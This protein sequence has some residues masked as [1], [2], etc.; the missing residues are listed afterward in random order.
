MKN[1]RIT[2][3]DIAKEAGVGIATVSRVLNGNSNVKENTRNKVIEIIKKYNFKPNTAARNLVNQSFQETVIGVIVPRIDTQFIFEV[4]AGLYRNL[5]GRDYNILIF[6]AGKDRKAVFSHLV[7]EHLAGLI[8]FGDPPMSKDEQ[9]LIRQSNIPYIF[10][11]HHEEGEHFVSYNNTIG[12]E[13]AAEYLYEKGCRKISF[14]GLTDK[15]QQQRERLYSFKKKLNQLNIDQIREIYVPDELSSYN[16]TMSILQKD[17][18]DG[19]FYFSDQLAF[20]GIRAKNELH[21]SASIIGYDDIFSSQFM[22]LSSIRQ[23]AVQIA[24]EGIIQL[25]NLIN[26]PVPFYHNKPVQVVLTPELVNRNS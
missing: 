5:K 24:D 9:N 19:I 20:G 1:S 15:T 17:I 25:V 12:G 4:L 18:T 16:F 10:L 7:N 8:L 11:D 3:K 2:I 14:M 22:Q 13:L 26:S 23:S 21:S 6:N